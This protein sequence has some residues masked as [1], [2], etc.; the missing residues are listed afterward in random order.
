[1]P[2]SAAERFYDDM[3][4]GS[5][6]CHYLNTQ[7]FHFVLH[8]HKHHPYMCRV[9]YAGASGLYVLAAGSATQSGEDQTSASFN[10]ID[11]ISPF[12]G[13]V[14]RYEYLTTGFRENTG[15]RQT[16]E[17]RPVSSFRYTASPIEQIADQDLR[18]ILTINPAGFESKH[19]LTSISCEVT[20]ENDLYRGRCRLQGVCAND[21]AEGLRQV[22]T[23]S[24]DRRWDE[25]AVRAWRDQLENNTV[26]C[27]VIEDHPRQKCFELRHATIGRAGRAFDYTYEFHWQNDPADDTY[28][29]AFNFFYYGKPIGEFGYS[30]T[31]PWQPAGVQVVEYGLSS[32]VVLPL[33]DKLEPLAD[34]RFRYSFRLE[35]PK[36]LLYVFKLPKIGA[37]G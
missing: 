19:S 12:Q 2:D 37:R 27:K 29:D 5:T 7:D 22:L 31:L 34:G 13:V 20:V 18:N 10:V 25:L 21:G 28:F 32:N 3:Q 35:N 15:L 11:L 6:L 17:P 1:V 16:I 30:I 26:V 9:Q 4:D 36:L 23:G 14:R 8:G 24:P 33:D